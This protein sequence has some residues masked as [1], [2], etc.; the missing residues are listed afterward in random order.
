MPASFPKTQP[1]FSQSISKIKAIRQELFKLTAISITSTIFISPTVAADKA[2]NPKLSKF[3]TSVPFS[4]N[5]VKPII[6]PGEIRLMTQELEGLIARFKSTLL[7]A[8]ANHENK[9]LS[10]GQVIKL[11][12][13]SRTNARKE[14]L[15]LAKSNYQDSHQALESATKRLQRFRYLL[16]QRKYAE[17]KVEWTAAKQILLDNYPQDRPLAQSE[18]R[19]MWLDRGTIVKAKSK[20]DL[21]EV[22]DRMAIAGINTVFFETLNSSY[23]IYPSQIAP[24]QN[25]LVSGWDP[26]EAAVKLA[27]E[28]GMELHAW[29]WIFAAANQRHNKILNQPRNYLGPVLSQR[30][31][32]AITDH[33]G[34]RFHY[35]SGKVF[36]DPANPEV[37]GYLSS[38]INEIATNY[39]V[40]GIHLDYIRYPFQSPTGKLTYGYGA[41]AREKFQIQTGFDPMQLNP[42]HPLWSTWTE[43]RIE[44]IDSFVAM[45][46][47]ELRQ[48]RPE[49]ILST[50]VFPMPQR[51]RL[52]KI[53]QSWEKWVKKEW[54]DLLVPMTYARNTDSLNSLTSP[55]LEEFD[56]GKA[57]LLPGIR[58]LNI[59]DVVALDQMQL[60]R[61]MSTQGYALFAAENLN[62]HL[63]K[64]FSKTQGNTYPLDEQL[65]PFRKPFKTALSRYQ[66]LQQEW[67]FTLANYSLE[68]D[69]ST[70]E[71]WGQ[72]AQ[73][74]ESELQKLIDKPNS[75]NFFLTQVTLDSMRQQ[76]PYWMKQSQNV[77][78]YQAAVWQSRLDTIDHLLSYGERKTL[79]RR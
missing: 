45:I 55:L 39:N 30:P 1:L 19:G 6:S 15:K 46:S 40:D 21:A 53:Q 23:T 78:V 47:D 5:H 7:T 2:S 54:I 41:A 71:I 12:L 72:Q 33:Q 58:L 13:E 70:L 26:L 64:I 77:D 76:F 57:L 27:H 63:I 49:L 34:S 11:L 14:N 16:T 31:D 43:F 10:T 66:S 61:G 32:W 68:I 8:D 50:A 60:L 25:P 65:L 22:F 18:V 37:R 24:R 42:Y 62:S 35:S 36:L 69:N 52:S 56:H 74:L 51:E 17:A 9:R 3:K 38:L 67:N 28:R 20:A 79:E 29:V 48:I 73:R 4:D 44:Q 75:R 59:S